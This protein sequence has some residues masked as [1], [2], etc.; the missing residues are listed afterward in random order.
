MAS[1]E[2][3]L[4]DRV[5]LVRDIIAFG[6][7]R[8]LSMAADMLEHYLDGHGAMREVSIHLLRLN[9]RFDGAR[10][11][12]LDRMAVAV[13]R[14]IAELVAEG[15]GKRRIGLVMEEP[16]IREYISGHWLDDLY[17]ASGKS[18]IEGK[19][20]FDVRV[21]DGEIEI[22]GWADLRWYDRYWWNPLEYSKD[23][24][25]VMGSLIG[26][27]TWLQA[28]HLDELRVAG[29]AAPFDMESRWDERLVRGRNFG[30]FQTGMFQLSPSV[31]KRLV[32]DLDHCERNRIVTPRLVEDLFSDDVR[33]IVGWTE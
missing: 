4:Q 18:T 26:A 1:S 9:Q 20:D 19:P 27:G 10:K 17:W 3:E 29:L 28:R 7:R 22:D 6:R 2:S 16:A 15:G 33:G 5:L 31:L 32:G 25:V 23:V 21:R 12:L 8:N 14:H 13:L 24:P 30:R 11:D